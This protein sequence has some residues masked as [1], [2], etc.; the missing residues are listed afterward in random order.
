MVLKL[1][2]AQ[3]YYHSFDSPRSAFSKTKSI[4]RRTFAAV[5]VLTLQ[6]QQ[7]VICDGLAALARHARSKMLNCSLV[8]EGV[9]S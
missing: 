8:V 6:L 7:N 2:V 3:R 1:Q 4:Q 9:N 5:S